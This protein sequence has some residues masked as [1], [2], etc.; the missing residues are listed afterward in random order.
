[1]TFGSGVTSRTFRVPVSEDA[2][3]EGNETIPL[4]LSNPSA[5]ATIGAQSSAT[6]TIIDDDNITPP[7]TQPI[8]DTTRFVNQHFHDFLNREADSG[9]LNFWVGEI[10]NVCQGN[11]ACIHQRR[12]DVSAAFFIELEFQES[13]A[14][15]YRL[16]RAAFG[17]TQPFPNTAPDVNV[18]PNVKA[19]ELPNYRVFVPDRARVVGGANLNAG[20][21][22]FANIFVQRAEFLQRYPAN[23]TASAFV[24]AVLTTVQQSS[25]VT[26]TQTERDAF[27]SDVTNSGRGQM[28]KNLAD[29]TAF[30]QAEF[31]RGF[32]LMQYFGYLRRNPDMGGYNFWLNV[33]N[34]NPQNF[35]GMVC[36]FITSFE[37]QDRFS[38]LHTR[39]NN[40]CQ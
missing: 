32:V 3:V 39:S 28:M 37:Y 11:S 5:G 36:S 20:K 38:T 15:V 13:G 24:T 23:L 19:A 18:P 6:L 40:D 10:D 21:L 8:E 9:G 35:G 34:Q 16:Y 31:K 33:L 30:S 2:Y 22:A 1:L 7:I 26:F 12:I 25:G 27:V 29:S 4:T 14:Y 17:A